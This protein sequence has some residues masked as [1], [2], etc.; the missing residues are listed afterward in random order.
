LNY[1]SECL[2]AQLG[3]LS[4]KGFGIDDEDPVIIVAGVLV[5]YLKDCQKGELKHIKS[6]KKYSYSDY[7]QLDPETI[8][9]LELVYSANGNEQ[10]TLYNVLNK[11]STA[12]GKRNLRRWIIY[13]LINKDKLNDRLN[14]VDKFYQNPILVNDIDSILN[15]ISDIERI[16]GRIG[17]ASA[18]PRDL[19]ALKLSLLN[20]AQIIDLLDS[21]DNLSQRLKSL[22]FN[23]K[24]SDSNVK[25]CIDNVI[26]IINESIDDEPSATLSEVGI[27][28]TGFNK[29]V[30]EIRS[31]RQNSKQI[32]TKMQSDE[33]SRTGISSLKISFNSVFG[34]YIEVTKTHISKVPDNYIRKQTLA[35]AER[36][37]TQELK[38]LE[39]KILSSEDK[40]IKLE[41]VLFIEVRNKVAEFIT[42]IQ[43]VAEIIA[44]IDC[45]ISF[46]KV[47]KNNRYIKPEIVEENILNI[48]DS[49]H[50]VIERI[51]GDFVPN[52]VE[53]SDQALIH[54]LTGPNMSGKSTYIRQVALITLMA[55]IGSFVPAQ[56]MQWSLT[57]RIFTRVGATDN[58]SKGESTFMVEMNETA[59]ILNNA[60]QKSLIILDEVGRGTSTYDGVAIAWSIIEFIFE[61]LKA[62]TL[63]ATHYH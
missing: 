49:R 33:V 8:R 53:F 2:L 7:M 17:T 11:S 47:A 16:A 15:K 5:N 9:N 39:E 34:Y 46:A 63:F 41:Q 25:K 10:N 24:D 40:L 61:K 27:I 59:N 56:S 13:P 14:S 37:I 43:E 42:E 23:F 19:I 44:E 35:N 18:N 1:A 29:E 12:M 22:V 6:I 45:Y 21:Q 38:E 48:K 32:L 30:D 36:Y 55:Q 51:V 54:I 58:L 4:V 31:L 57:D 52:S 28:K 3:V 60:T 62:K 50:P 26:A 20:I